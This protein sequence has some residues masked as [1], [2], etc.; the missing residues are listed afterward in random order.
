MASFKI[1][2]GPDWDKLRKSFKTNEAVQKAVPD[3]SMSILKF[4]NVLEK[5]VS[6]LFNTPGKLSDVMIGR[7][8]APSEIGKTFLR[9]N[10]QY[11]D[12]PVALNR[13]NYTSNAVGSLSIAPLRSEPLGRVHW[14]KGKYSKKLMFNIRKGKPQGQRI[15]GNFSKQ[16]AFIGPDR[17]IMARTTSSTW[18][19]YPKK[20]FAGIRAPYQELFGPSL[21]T[22]ANKVYDKDTQVH[23]AFEQMQIDIANALVKG[24]SL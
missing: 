8:V 24:Y 18:D 7:S 12:I 14:K 9:Y 3:I 22:I 16:G 6:D 20:G 5:R 17:K 11:R 21:M 13:F 2:F 23:K 15:G 19:R 1:D 4:H 10:L